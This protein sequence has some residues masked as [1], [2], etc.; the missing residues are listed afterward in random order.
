[1]VELFLL[2]VGLLK[3]GIFF[4]LVHLQMHL[5][6][7]IEVMLVMLD[8]HVE[9]VSMFF[10]WRKFHFLLLCWKH[11]K[12]IAAVKHD[13]ALLSE[14]FAYITYETL[15]GLRRKLIQ[16]CSHHLAFVSL[17]MFLNYITM[18]MCI[19]AELFL[20]F[21]FPLAGLG[22]EERLLQSPGYFL[23]DALESPISKEEEEILK[24]VL[25]GVRLNLGDIEDKVV[26]EE[27]AAEAKKKAFRE[28]LKTYNL[29]TAYL[30]FS[31]STVIIC[32]VLKVR[33]GE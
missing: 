9:A 10:K 1:M 17:I 18:P 32:Q 27:K 19:S 15:K 30:A 16:S 3:A 23:S 11:R 28:A 13:Y 31:F 29:Y 24:K 21:F 4:F 33:R 2:I 7:V 20:D 14:Y 8:V 25:N 5:P 6:I 12:L 26:A 22:W